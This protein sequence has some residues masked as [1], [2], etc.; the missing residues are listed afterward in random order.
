MAS[1]PGTAP[2]A[3]IDGLQSSP[4]SFK[5][6]RISGKASAGPFSSMSNLF[7]SGKRIALPL[8][9]ANETSTLLDDGQRTP[10]SNV[11]RRVSRVISTGAGTARRKA[12]DLLSPGGSVS[13][14]KG[15]LN[16]TPSPNRDPVDGSDGPPAIPAVLPEYSPPYST[17]LPTLPMLV[18]CLAMLGEFL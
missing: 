14:G 13:R 17:P 12:G 5:R 11:S 3:E 7:S 9:D 4:L 18:L 1:E 16:W 10:S 8:G 15:V 2:P 6:R